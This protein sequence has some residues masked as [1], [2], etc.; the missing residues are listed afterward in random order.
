MGKARAHV[1]IARRVY[2]RHEFRRRGD[3]QGASAEDTQ[4]V[5]DHR[6]F[7]PFE[8]EGVEQPARNRYP[9][10]AQEQERAS[11]RDDVP[12]TFP[13]GIHI[14][15]SCNTV[16]RR[17][18]CSGLPTLMRKEFLNPGLSKYRTNMPAWA[19]RC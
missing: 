12:K 9:H 13:P 2:E 3:I 8:F 15:H 4:D 16:T 7:L 19:N 6:A 17:S 10:Q 18:V 5:D 11:P 1:K 14:A